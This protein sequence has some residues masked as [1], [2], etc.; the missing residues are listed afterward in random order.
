MGKTNLHQILY[1]AISTIMLLATIISCNGYKYLQL[2]QIEPGTLESRLSSKVSEV[3]D[4]RIEGELGQKDVEYIEMLAAESDRLYSIDLE[5]SNMQLKSRLFAGCSTL[6]RVSLPKTS[7]ELPAM[8]MSGCINLEE[9]KISEECTYIGENCFSKCTSLQT[10]TIPEN[11]EK[12]DNKVFKDC[13]HLRTIRVTA[14]TP[15]D[16]NK[17]TFAGFDTDSC[18][19]VVKKGCASKFRNSPGWEN[20]GTIEEQKH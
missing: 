16:C 8:L 4:L 10:I 11:V 1:A 13:T 15:P 18:T 6:K 14:Q 5:N 20:F 19:L 17:A 2:N 7:Q 9:V 12:L 3:T